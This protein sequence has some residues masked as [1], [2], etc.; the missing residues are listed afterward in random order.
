MKC[1]L[2]I[3]SMVIGSVFFS[4]YALADSASLPGY[5]G[6]STQQPVPVRQANLN[7]L[8]D[9]I[10]V[11]TDAETDKKYQQILARVKKMQ[12][13]R[14]A[15]QK[16]VQQAEQPIHP[17]KVPSVASLATP[18]AKP[19]PKP[20]T[21]NDVAFLKVLNNMN[22]L[23]PDQIKMMHAMYQRTQE[24][25]NYPSSAQ[26]P[27]IS[28]INVDLQPSAVP[29][30]ISLA[31]G[32]VTSLEFLDSTGQPWP[33]QAIDVGNAKDYSAKQ[34]ALGSKGAAGSNTL[35]L[36]SLS[37]VAKPGNL[38]IMLQGLA[39]PI[40]LALSTNQKV[41]NY[42]V[43]LHIPGSGPNALQISGAGVSSVNNDSVL[44]ALNGVAPNGSKAVTLDGCP[45]CQAW[46]TG[47]YLFLR[48]KR[49]LLSPSWSKTSSSA[50]GTN[51]YQ[52]PRAPVLLAYL[53]GNITKIN[54][55]Y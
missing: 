14:A 40:M 10:A 21:Q 16:S 41:I 26:K 50:D 28:S 52:L 5:A 42:R 32:I 30:V 51:A 45:D 38:A 49:H 13:T 27:S 55:E 44:T 25:T 33:I 20:L 53:N 54:V 39:T 3:I 36:Q 1:R 47:K 34:T 48:T 15:Q 46:E 22:P 17:V 12:S 35:W 2:L 7:S 9:P 23:T 4:G 11:P 6:A 29:P 24:A 19:K 8:N 31:P 43:D 18:V 37:E